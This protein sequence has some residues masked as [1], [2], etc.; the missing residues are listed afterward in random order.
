ML[1]A[2]IPVMVT[3]VPVTGLTLAILTEAVVQLPDAALVQL[4][5]AFAHMVCEPP[6]IA[7]GRLLTV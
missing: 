2:A 7:A 4:V 1:P 3:E 5:V 6:A